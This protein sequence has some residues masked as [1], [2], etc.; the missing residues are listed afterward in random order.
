M[1]N[2]PKSQHGDH[3]RPER[4]I[5]NLAR[6]LWRI[7]VPFRREYARYLAGIAVRQGLLVF[8]GYSLVLVLR[9]ASRYTS[10]PIWSFAAVLLLLDAGLL[11]LDLVLNTRYSTRVGYPLFGFLRCRALAKMF[12]MPLEWHIQRDSGIVAGH[13]NNGVGKV[14][15]TAEAV[16]RELVPALIRTA[17]SLV[18][19]LCF[20]PVTAPLILAGLAV[21]LWQTQKENVARQPLRKARYA[22][23]ARDHGLFSECLEYVQPVVHFGQTA[24]ILQTYEQVQQQIV[25]EGAAEVAIG[26]R[27]SWRRNL[28]LSATKR[29]CQALWLWR[30]RSGQLD[31]ALVMYLNMLTEDLLNSFW[32]YASLIER[33]YEGMEPARALLGIFQEKAHIRDSEGVRPIALR[34][35]I[36]IKVENLRFGYQ[37]GEPVLKKFNLSIA[38]GCVV[39][40]TGR[41]GIGKTTLQHLLS[42]LLEAQDGRI[43]ISGEDVRHWPLEQLRGLFSTVSQNGGV[44]FS[45]QTVL[46]TIRFA[47]PEASWDEVEACSR[48]ACIHDDIARMPLG[49]DT[50]IGRSGATLSKGQQQRIALAQAL[51]ALDDNRR[52]V[53]LDEFTSALDAE[54]E[55]RI[56]RNILPLLKGRTVILIAHRLAT[57]RKLADT[58]VVIDRAGVVESGSHAELV[59][60]G[61]WY[62]EMARL[63]ATA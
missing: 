27:Y 50:K 29:L 40:V 54:T 19:L 1:L 7:L 10:I 14:V 16:S 32:S 17:L 63:Q 8:A 11:R 38:P 12:E 43:L 39:G 58:I 41:S 44:F 34:D 60:S 56:L 35:S 5:R 53:I 36:G 55:E 61:G 33:V 51:L 37:S 46:E 45:N 3:P 2:P 57:V 24:R 15:Q 22:N 9:A 20:S 48:A 59:R 62:S 21:F 6:D 49:Y 26:N 52:I 31:I 30:W 13:I 18:P 25:R 28:L 4:Q 23:Y 42:R 47:R